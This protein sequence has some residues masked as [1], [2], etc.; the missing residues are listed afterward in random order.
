MRHERLV[1]DRALVDEWRVASAA[2]LDVR[3]AA[4]RIAVCATN[5]VDA[6]GFWPKDR[7][8]R[9]EAARREGERMRAFAASFPPLKWGATG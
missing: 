3:A 1:F 4:E 2:G 7:A 6:W 8:P 5:V 9:M